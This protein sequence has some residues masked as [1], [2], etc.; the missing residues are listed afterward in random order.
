MFTF[1]VSILHMISLTLLNPVEVEEKGNIVYQKSK[2][3]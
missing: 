3:K 2:L 1:H